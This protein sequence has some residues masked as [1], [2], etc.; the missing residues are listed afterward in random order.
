MRR[1]KTGRV[2]NNLLAKLGP[3]SEVVKEEFIALQVVGSNLTS[4]TFSKIAGHGSPR[5][6][7]AIPGRRRVQNPAL[8][9]DGKCLPF[10]KNNAITL[11]AC[12]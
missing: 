5:P 8:L 10:T 4:G 7:Q 9:E 12:I 1:F 6:T 11:T 3:C 2:D